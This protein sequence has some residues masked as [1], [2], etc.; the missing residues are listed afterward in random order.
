MRRGHGLRIAFFGASLATAWWNGAA[1]YYCGILR[2]LHARGHHITFYAPAPAGNLGAV[3][4]PPWAR[5]STGC[6]R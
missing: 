4:S 2:A 1:M 3:P 6:S 5:A